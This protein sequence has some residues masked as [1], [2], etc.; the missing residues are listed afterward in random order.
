MDSEPAFLQSQLPSSSNN[1]SS[2]N[3]II[4][5]LL[6]ILV[7]SLLGI[8]LFTIMGEGLQKFINF[9][10]PF[11]SDLGYDTGIIIDKS[12]DVLSDA[13]KT[14]IDILNGTVHSVGDLL[15]KASGENN[16]HN[17]I[18]QPSTKP[19]TPP[20]PAHSTN[21]VLNTPSVNKSKWC[22]VGEYNGN[23]GCISISDQDKCLS[24]QVFPSQKMCLNPT[25]TQNS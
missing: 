15:I 17:N 12:S 5:A 9:S 10:K 25:L 3:I 2:K 14:G 6:I 18:N 8:N 19:P 13:S 4:I 16:E 24:G 21:P 1:D 20:E 7:L 23:R 11:I 22:L